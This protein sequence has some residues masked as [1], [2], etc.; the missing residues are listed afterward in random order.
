[1]SLDRAMTTPIWD[2]VQRY[3]QSDPLRLHMPGHKGSPFLGCEPL[4]ITEIQ[5][6]DSLYEA[7]GIIA[8]S[9]QNAAALF[10]T[11]RTF[12]STEG[13]S[14]CIRAMLFAALLHAGAQ[15]PVI[16]AA[17]NAHRAF[18]YAAAVL[19]IDVCWI[20]GESAASVCS[21]TV[22]PDDLNRALDGLPEPPIAVYITSPDYLG[23]LCDVAGL[24]AVAH[25][26]HIPLL[27]DNAHGAYLKFLSPSLHPM[28]LG[29]DMCCDS[30][31]KTLPVL[32]GGAYLHV[33]KN[34]PEAFSALGKEALAA[35]G[36]TSPSYLILQSLDLCNR[37]L[38][39]GYPDRLSQCTA[40]L[41]ALKEA[42]SAR[43]YTLRQ[44]DPLKLTLALSQRDR[45]AL[46]AHLRARGIEFEFQDLHFL[47]FMFTP[48]NTPADLDRLWEA[49][50]SYPLADPL[51]QP[52]EWR[53][54]PEKVLSVHDAFFA[55]RERLPLKQ[56]IGRIC[57]EP[58]VSCP[59][60]V[61]IVVCGERISRE[62]AQLLSR[63]GVEEIA[64]VR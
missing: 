33:S 21:C 50:K 37:H 34:A 49:I 20:H 48:E 36:S 59:P 25:R 6:A 51:F 28:D 60:A 63:Y 15:R 16:L 53:L 46:P 27:V 18:L 42:L 45:T 9:E 17:R 5:G 12:Y 64:V 39:Q 52:P 32:T 35:F 40:R 19:N 62:A 11:R 13:S 1:M 24:A 23:A 7:R 10:G 38:S 8:E 3:R 31:H 56:A 58:S 22:T 44:S 57:G 14:L 2:F 61:P 41:A 54:S 47:V 26:R 55:P 4:D 43:G 30:A 29:A